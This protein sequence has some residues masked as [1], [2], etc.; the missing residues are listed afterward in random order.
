MSD[1]KS[2]FRDAA[3]PEIREFLVACAA[4]IATAKPPLTMVSLSSIL[5]GGGSQIERLEKGADITT[6]RLR[7]AWTRLRELEAGGPRTRTPSSK[8]KRSQ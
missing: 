5:M 7:T 1:P 6:G 4:F 8:A 2:P 3:T